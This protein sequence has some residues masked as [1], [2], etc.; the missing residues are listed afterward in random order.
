MITVVAAF[1][2]SALYG[3]H[4]PTIVHLAAS[5]TLAA[6]FFTMYRSRV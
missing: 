3:W 1:S 2:L 5:V 6:L 4:G